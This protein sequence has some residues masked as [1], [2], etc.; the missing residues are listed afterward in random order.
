[1][2][3]SWTRGGVETSADV[4]IRRHKTL[5]NFL[6]KAT[7]DKAA[8]DA[9]AD[10]QPAAKQ[11][12]DTAPADKAASNKA[13]A[14]KAE[15]DRVALDK[16][17][18]HSDS[19]GRARSSHVHVGLLLLRWRGPAR[20]AGQPAQQSCLHSRAAGAAELPAQ[21]RLHSSAA[22]AGPPALQSGLDWP[23]NSLDSEITW[24][25]A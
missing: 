2:R 15:T 10:K 17:P 21:S 1:M 9:T 23:S 19:G 20:A 7:A 11:A 18:G 24:P 25:Q 8:A 5:S 3:G 13:A 6:R 4:W 14:G 22:C 16:A 12:A